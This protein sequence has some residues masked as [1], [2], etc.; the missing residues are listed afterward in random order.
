MHLLINPRKGYFGTVA[1]VAAIAWWVW[2]VNSHW[3]MRCGSFLGYEEQQN[4]R[5]IEY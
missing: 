2:N 5:N 3:G 4:F 1:S